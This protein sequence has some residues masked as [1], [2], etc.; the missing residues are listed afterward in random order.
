MPTPD[1]FAY[2]KAPWKSDPKFLLNITVTNE[3]GSEAVI[4]LDESWKWRKKSRHV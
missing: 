1:L 4:G 2:E 3:D